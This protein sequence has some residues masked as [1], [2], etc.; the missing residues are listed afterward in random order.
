MAKGPDALKKAVQGAERAGGEKP[1]G[2]IEIPFVE[3]QVNRTL[4]LGGHHGSQVLGVRQHVSERLHDPFEH[5]FVSLA[6]V[7]QNL[8]DVASM[9]G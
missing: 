3:L 5:R 2:D 6:N 8:G 1:T 7:E 4:E 9:F